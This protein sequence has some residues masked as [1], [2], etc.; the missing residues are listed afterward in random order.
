[1][2]TQTLKVD[3]K[4]GTY[5]YVCDIHANMEGKLYVK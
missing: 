1:M 4:A 3:L 5:D 2:P